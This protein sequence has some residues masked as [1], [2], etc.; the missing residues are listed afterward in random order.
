ML[1]LIGG[2]L[3]S[4]GS[5]T[6]GKDKFSM[7]HLYK[8]T[9][10]INSICSKHDKSNSKVID[11][12]YNAIKSPSAENLCEKY[13]LKSFFLSGAPVVQEQYAD[14]AIQLI[15]RKGLESSQPA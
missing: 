6:G 11:S 10:T 12:M 1:A 9:D 4:C 8:I 3:F 2:S 5:S 13:I 7:A 14:S 15:Y